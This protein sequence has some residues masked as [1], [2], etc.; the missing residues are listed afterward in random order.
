MLFRQ[1]LLLEEEGL[2]FDSFFFSVSFFRAGH[3]GIRERERE[4]PAGAGGLHPDALRYPG[5]ARQHRPHHGRG[6][7]GGQGQLR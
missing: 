3:D 4:G 1:L 5:A 6:C 2:S 7:H